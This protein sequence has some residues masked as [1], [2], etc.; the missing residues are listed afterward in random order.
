M[1]SEATYALA[2]T[3]YVCRPLD[4]VVVK[5]KNKPVLVYELIGAK[6]RVRD[7]AVKAVRVYIEGFEA[8]SQRKFKKAEKR[9][10]SFLDL[11]LDDITA[12]KHLRACK[13][14]Q[15]NPPPPDWDGVV[16]M[17]EK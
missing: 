4:Y 7:E 1:I 3:R 8:M 16:K 13:E 17:T 6:E 2:R 15:K 11:V 12:T 5:G 10:K 9:F 14:Y